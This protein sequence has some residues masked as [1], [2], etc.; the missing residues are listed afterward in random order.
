MFKDLSKMEKAGLI[1]G[2]LQCVAGFA[3]AMCARKQILKQADNMIQEIKDTTPNI[4]EMIF[5]KED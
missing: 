4:D 5:G 3:L 2:G 1:I